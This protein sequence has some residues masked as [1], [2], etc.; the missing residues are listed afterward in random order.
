MT[1]HAIS[2]LTGSRPHSRPEKHPR[3]EREPDEK[4]DPNAARKEVVV[5]K[6][7]SKSP[8]GEDQPHEE[9]ER[10]RENQ[11]DEADEQRLA[12]G[13]RRPRADHE[14]NEKAHEYGANERRELVSTKLGQDLPECRLA[15]R[16]VGNGD[17]KH[18]NPGKRVADQNRYPFLILF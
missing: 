12:A 15:K 4:K 6:D 16:A 1:M 14:P 18:E 8:V 13:R 17:H 5:S 7:L 10:H 2:Q 3:C 11:P 9:F